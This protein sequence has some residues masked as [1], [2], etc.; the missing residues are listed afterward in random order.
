MSKSLHAQI[1][2]EIQR[3]E[4]EKLRKELEKQATIKE[5]ILKDFDVFLANL[6]ENLED[7][8]EHQINP[9]YIYSDLLAELG[10]SFYI[11]DNKYFV[12]VP[13]FEKGSRRT[14]A[15]LKLFKFEQELRK[16]RQEKKKEVLAECHKVK[17]LIEIGEY[18]HFLAYE[19]IPT[20]IWVAS[21]KKFNTNYENE[22]IQSFFSKFQLPFTGYQECAYSPFIFWTFSL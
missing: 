9:K 11:R 2:E 18:D 19:D 10:F 21:F 7:Y 3:R 8:T 1:V 6:L 16:V 4:K 12:S 17:H 14:P 22:L 5:N 13:S 20:R 15:Q